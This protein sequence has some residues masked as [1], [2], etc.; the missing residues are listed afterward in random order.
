MSGVGTALGIVLAAAGIPRQGGARESVDLGGEWEF[1]MDPEDRGLAEKWF[2]E[3]IPF[4]RKIRVPGAWNAQGVAYASESQLRE[5]EKLRL[6]GTHLLGTERE[7]E[8]LFIVFPGPAWYRKAIRIPPSWRGRVP[9]LVFEGIHRYGDVWVNGEPAGSSRSYLTP[10]RIELSRWA[11]DGGTLSVVVRVDARRDRSIDPL[12]GCLD[13]LDFLYA[14]WGGLHRKVRLEAT[15]RAW[16]EDVYARPFLRD[17]AVE[18]RAAVGGDRGRPLRWTAAVTDPAGREVARG[19]GPAGETLRLAIPAPRPWT[20]RSPALYTVRARL[21]EGEEAQDAVTVRFGMREF[22][23]DGGRFLLNGRPVFLRGTGDDCI[24]P[25]TLAPPADREEFRRR[26]AAA[27]DYGFNYIRC[28][29]WFPPEEYLDAADELGMMVQPEFPIAYRW[30]LPATPEAKK[31]LLEQWAA[32]IRLHRNHPSIVAWCIRIEEPFLRHGPP[33]AEGTGPAP[34][35]GGL[36]VTARADAATLDFL[37]QGGRVLLLEP[38]PFFAVERTR[39]RLSSWDGGG[40]TGTVID[41][42]HP[43][44]RGMPS[45][46]WADLH[47]YPLIQN[48]KAIFLDPLP[49]PVHPIIRCIDRFQRLAHRAYL[50]EAGV[51]KGRLLVS[52]FDFAGALRTGDPAAVFLFDRLIAYAAGPEFAPTAA[53]PLEGLRSRLKK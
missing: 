20:P 33:A 35:G 40:P 52:G 21:L 48:S 27:R 5:Y 19:E 45:D 25:N 9:W 49:S 3:K 1:R 34:P 22:A 7:S 13:T 10:L 31:R 24:F 46:G 4:D 44:L 23:V 12:M 14:S 43:A 50:F 36:L 53:I 42:N 2:E 30:D 47:F 41:T 17:A 32:A 8:R 51:G 16:L 11:G 26:L 6:N 29:S 39:Y 38:E 28:H 37:E 15:G 18:I